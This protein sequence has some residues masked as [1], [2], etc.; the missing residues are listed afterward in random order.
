MPRRDTLEGF[1]PY[2]MNRVM[3][4]YNRGVEDALRPLGISVGQ[5]RVL[6]VLSDSGPRTVNELSVLTVIRQS[7][8]SRALDSLES[9]G[10]VLR[11]AVA[12]DSRARSVSLTPAGEALHARAWPAVLGMRDTMLAALSPDEG[13]ALNRLL[14]KIFHDIRHH[15]F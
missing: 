13:A 14:L 8:L 9:A 3:A 7:T 5:M 11:A 15:D 2:V 10:L 6:A 4:R 1:T 12:G